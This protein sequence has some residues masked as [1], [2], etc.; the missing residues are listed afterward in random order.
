MVKSRAGD[1]AAAERIPLPRRPRPRRAPGRA[2][3][4]PSS[5]SA[6]FITRCSRAKRSAVEVSFTILSPKRG[7]RARSAA[8]Q[9]G[10]LP[11]RPA[12]ARVGLGR[13][14]LRSL[15]R[16]VRELRIPENIIPAS[17]ERRLGERRRDRLVGSSPMLRPARGPS[18]RGRCDKGFGIDKIVEAH[19]ERVGVAVAMATLPRIWPP[20]SAIDCTPSRTPRTRSAGW[21]R[22]RRTPSSARCGGSRGFSARRFGQRTCGVLPVVERGPLST[23]SVAPAPPSSS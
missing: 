14:R 5:E 7:V 9:Y 12:P 21:R 4:P 15:R 20:A 1:L 6:A 22:R 2:Q 13:V 3:G 19:K 16:G 10:H 17:S 23:R 8:A 18:W 11:D